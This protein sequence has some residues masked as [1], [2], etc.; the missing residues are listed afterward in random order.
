MNSIAP[1][2]SPRFKS[3]H[4]VALATLGGGRPRRAV[5]HGRRHAGVFVQQ[6]PAYRGHQNERGRLRDT[7]AHATASRWLRRS[8]ALSKS[9]RCGENGVDVFN[10]LHRKDYDEAFAL[11][12]FDLLCGPAR[13]T[14]TKLKHLASG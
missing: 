8:T 14:A 3:R 2:R 1:N 10:F 9:C 12:A 11:F 7:R 5:D 6:L 4:M 13:L